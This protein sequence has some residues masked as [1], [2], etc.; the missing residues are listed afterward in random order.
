MEYL[1]GINLD[2][3]LE[4]NTI[5]KV[6]NVIL[7]AQGFLNKYREDRVGATIDIMHDVLVA[8]AELH[9]NGYVH[10]DI[11]PSNV[12]L[13]S[14]D[15]VKIIDFGIS[16]NMNASADG[17]IH[18]LTAYGTIMGKMAYAAPEVVKGYTDMHNFSTDVYSLG[19]MMYQLAVGE[20]P[21]IGD[22]QMVRDAQ[23]NKLVPVENISHW[24]LSELVRKATEKDQLNRY[25]NAQEMLDAFEQL[26]EQGNKPEELPIKSDVSVP[27]WLWGVVPVVGV[28]LGIILGLLMF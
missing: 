21:F 12:M 15:S 14:L 9:K 19:I 11:D 27:T 25:Q 20:L 17:H 8:V 1:E 16:R 24:G 2:S 4:G 10:R 3:I 7:L 6:G 5:S 13:T 26:K 28:V 18:K 22:S 23:V